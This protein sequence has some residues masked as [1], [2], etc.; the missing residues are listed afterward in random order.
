MKKILLFY[1]LAISCIFS[2]NNLNAQYTPMVA[3]SKYWIYYDF[4]ARARPTT[5]FAITMQGDTLVNNILYKKVYKCELE[6]ELKTIAI[7]EPMQFVATFPYKLLDKKLVSLMRE[8]LQNKKVYNLPIKQDSCGP[9]MTSIIN[10]CN[11]ILFCDSLEY[12]LFDFS[13][14]VGDTINYCLPSNLLHGNNFNLYKVDSIKNQFEFGHD[15]R[16]YFTYGYQSF[17][18]NLMNPG[19]YYPSVTKIYEGVGFKHQGIFHYIF[20]VLMDFCEGSMDACDIISSSKKV[21]NNNSV[22]IFPNPFSREFSVES[23]M[24]IKNIS[25]YDLNS[26]EILTVY[27]S[28]SINL[29]KFNNGI[30]FCRVELKNGVVVTKKIIKTE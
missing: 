14:N 17:I 11:N 22:N 26:T 16:T 5:G 9:D 29:E 23:D 27:E 24:E 7:N 8:D 3:E 18:P 12:V 1:F 15:R 13:Y 30:F 2:S 20:G 19:T 21:T 6:G 10:T 25:I 28:N 4:Q